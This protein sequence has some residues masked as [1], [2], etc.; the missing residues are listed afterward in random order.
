MPETKG[1]GVAQS[2]ATQRPRVLRRARPVRCD[3]CWVCHDR[4][5]TTLTNG[6]ASGSLHDVI[7]QE[8][9]GKPRSRKRIGN[10][11]SYWP[12]D[13]V[14]AAARIGNAAAVDRSCR[15]ADVPE[16]WPIE[17][18]AAAPR[19]TPI[20][21]RRG[22]RLGIRRRAPFVGVVPCNALNQNVFEK[23]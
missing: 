8:P 2:R 5:G 13:D 1:E 7:D 14:V 21:T 4:Q 12:T 9:A 22:E 16:A 11:Y 6:G 3:P 18:P 15:K 17:S 23:R 19:P 20:Q 10:K